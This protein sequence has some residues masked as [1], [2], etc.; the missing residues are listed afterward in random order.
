MILLSNIIIVIKRL[1]ILVK[2]D[3]KNFV[4]IIIF[5]I[6]KKIFLLIIINY[7]FSSINK[8]KIFY[9]FSI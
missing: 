4:I 3:F 2:L 5:K 9:N 7:N 6:K 1:L 8:F